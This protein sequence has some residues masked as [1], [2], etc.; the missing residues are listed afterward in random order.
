M[1]PSFPTDP[2]WIE[3]SK[4]F[5]EPFWAADTPE[6]RKK[7]GQGWISAMTDFGIPLDDPNA[8]AA[9]AETIYDH[10]RSRAMPLTKDARQHWP[11][12]ALEVLRL[13]ANQGFRKVPSDPFNRA[14]RIPAPHD[15]QP[16]IRI[17]RDIR[18]LSAAEIDE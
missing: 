5:S 13:W 18:S 10:L 16:E 2:T 11:D 12:S 9:N 4:L 1:T 6:E 8:V 17:R 3:V 7:I 14:D 15:P